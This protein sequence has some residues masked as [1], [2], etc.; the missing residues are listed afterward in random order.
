MPILTSKLGEKLIAW[1][2]RVGRDEGL[3]GPLPQAEASRRIGISRQTL[4]EIENG[5]R[6]PAHQDVIRAIFEVTGLSPAE[7]WEAA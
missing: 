3:R 2:T 7:W 5:K 1:R 4:I 6:I